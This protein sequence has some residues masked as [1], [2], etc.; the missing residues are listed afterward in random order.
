MEI[1]TCTT[2][3][4]DESRDQDARIRER[5]AALTT[6]A[7]GMDQT[8]QAHGEEMKNAQRDAQRA[9]EA[10]ARDVQAKQE[11]VM[12]DQTAV[13]ASHL[14]HLGSLAAQV[15]DMGAQAAKDRE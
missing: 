5:L 8:I 2:R 4:A 1:A 3:L 11:D 15:Q 7:E 12:R 9:T 10:I 6:R 13:T 14:E